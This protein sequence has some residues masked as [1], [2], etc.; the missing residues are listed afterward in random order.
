MIIKH[1]NIIYMPHISEL[2]RNRN[3]DIRDGKEI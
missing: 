1:D 2:R 3:V